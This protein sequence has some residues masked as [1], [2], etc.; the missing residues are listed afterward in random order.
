LLRTQARAS[1][2]GPSCGPILGFITHDKVNA[3][4][5]YDDLKGRVAALHTVL[6]YLLSELPADQQARIHDRLA[7]ERLTNPTPYAE[8]P[9]VQDSFVQA[10]AVLEFQL[11]PK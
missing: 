8:M 10:M 9:A 6:T 7:R 2:K 4:N 11:L 1:S 5:D 3:V